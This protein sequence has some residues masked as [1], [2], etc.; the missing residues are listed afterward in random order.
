MSRIRAID[1]A[2]G[3]CL[4]MMTIDHLP[5]N[6]FSRFSNTEFGPLG[7]FTAASIFVFLSGIASGQVYPKTLERHGSAGLW[8]RLGRKALQLYVVNLAILLVLY[9][10]MGLGVLR[11]PFWVHEFGLFDR[12]PLQ[13]VVRSVLL[14]YR[15]GYADILPMYVLFLL[16]LPPMLALLR[17][18]QRWLLLASSAALWA[19]AQSMGHPGT[20]NPFAYQTLFVAGVVCADLP[21]LAQARNNPWVKRLAPAA[22]GLALAL[23]VLRWAYGG[24]AELRALLEPLRQQ[25]SIEHN[26]PVRMANFALVTFVAWYL[27]P[28][29]V[30][31]FQD[32][33]PM[34]WLELLGSHSLV[35]FTWSVVGSYASV[36]LMGEHPTLGWKI[37]DVILTVATLVLPALVQARLQ[38]R[39][40]RGSRPQR[41]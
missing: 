19:A 25:A 28:R 11:G 14:M 33:R 40:H 8:Q 26:G 37:V 23:V 15:P 38:A 32:S 20:L 24:D 36:A 4:V 9:A 13:A 21:G 16:A 29:L 17:H 35:V 30:A 34:R 10:L 27:W 7:F 1:Q 2:R 18:G 5:D 22:I 3:Y 6:L 12:A 39:D 31:P 41:A